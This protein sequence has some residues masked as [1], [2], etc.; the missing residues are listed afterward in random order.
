MTCIIGVAGREG[1]VCADRRVTSETGERCPNLVKVYANVGLVVGI[2]GAAS[3]FYTVARLIREGKTDPRDFVECVGDHSTAL[4][5]TADR[6]LWWVSDEAAWPVRRPW[7][8]AGSGSDMATGFLGAR[9]VVDRA[10]VRE[11]QR[12]VAARRTDCG[13]GCDFR[14]FVKGGGKVKNGKAQ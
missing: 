10:S 11:A 1:F 6:A 4:C 9:G 2:C 13:G 12:F 7:V 5:L 14:T 8:A 3:T